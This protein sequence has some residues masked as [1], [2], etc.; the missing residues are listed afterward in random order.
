M[1]APSSRSAAA[2][3][4]T[5]VPA[6]MSTTTWNSDLLSKGSILRMTSCTA[7]SDTEAPMSTR[8]TAPR[9]ARHVPEPRNGFSRR[10]AAASSHPPPSAAWCGARRRN[11]SASQGVTVKAMA[12]EMSI[13]MLALIGI[14]L[15]YGPMRPVTKAMGRSAAITVK[16]ARIVGPPTSS[17]AAGMMPES[18]PDSRA[19]RRWMFSTTTMASSTRIPMEKMSAKSDTRFSVKPQAQE[20]KSVVASVSSTATPTMKASR[21]PSVAKTSTMT[22]SVAKI[23]FWISCCAL[24]LAVAP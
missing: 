12:S 4:S 16:V 17:T 7:A 8:T 20:A 14:G 9:I 1:C 21:Q 11:L 3:A 18:G 6:G 10:R 22:E 23:S 19:R 5:G 24:S 2:V 13:P 15:M